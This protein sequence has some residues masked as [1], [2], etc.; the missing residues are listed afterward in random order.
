M[1]EITMIERVARAIL[2]KV[3][4]GYGMRKDEARE[5]ARAAIEAMREPTLAMRK[6]CD[7]E[8]AEVTWP[9][10]IDAALSEGDKTS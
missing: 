3:P 4:I 2:A 10:L 7:F 6:V 8:C 9:K 1:S 5:Y